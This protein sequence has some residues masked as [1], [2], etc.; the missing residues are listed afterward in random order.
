[1][2]FSFGTK[3]RHVPDCCPRCGQGEEPFDG[4]FVSLLKRH[5]GGWTKQL[6]THPVFRSPVWVGRCGACEMER[7]V[8]YRS[9][10]LEYALGVRPPAGTH[11]KVDLT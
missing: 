1:M 7:Q 9:L 11:I 4:T 8:S 2:Q 5:Y 6:V 10:L 3:R